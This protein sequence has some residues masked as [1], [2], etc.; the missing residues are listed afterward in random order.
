MY[1]NPLP[2]ERHETSSSTDA[3]T[4]NSGLRFYGDDFVFDTVSGMFFR[5]SPTGSFILRTLVSGVKPDRL[6]A[7]MEARY[8]IDR[9]TA[10]R[11]IELFLNELSALEPLDRFAHDDQPAS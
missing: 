8:G 11:D 5:L 1:D 4:T 10:T 2:F 3:E 6:P 7:A 9:A